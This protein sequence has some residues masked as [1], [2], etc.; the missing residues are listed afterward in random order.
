MG[1][2]PVPSRFAI[3]PH[4]RALVLIAA[5][6]VVLQ[7]FFAGVAIAQTGAALASDP[8]GAICHGAGGA[9]PADPAPD[10]GKAGH[11]CCDY[12]TSPVPALAPPDAPAVAMPPPRRA[13]P[14][15]AFAGLL[16]VISAGAV[17]AGLSQA[18]PASA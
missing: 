16:F 3:R 4:R 8:I 13:S 5:L 12:C 10:T 9:A 18:P 6:L 11:L 7:A 1:E 2:V 15:P 14:L 17:R